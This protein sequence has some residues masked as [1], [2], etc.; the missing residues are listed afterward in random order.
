MYTSITPPEVICFCGLGNGLNAPVLIFPKRFKSK[1]HQFQAF[2]KIP[3]LKN[4]WF[5]MFQNFQTTCSF[6]ETTGKEP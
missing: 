5:P 4:L 1:N 3:E 2:E 6:N